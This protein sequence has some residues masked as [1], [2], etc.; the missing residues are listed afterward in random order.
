MENSTLGS[1]RNFRK[2]SLTPLV[3]SEERRR[4]HLPCLLLEVS[5]NTAA[6]PRSTCGLLWCCDNPA[7]TCTLNLSS[8]V[9]IT[10]DTS[11]P[12]HS[13]RQP[14]LYCLHRIQILVFYHSPVRSESISC[15]KL[16][17]SKRLPL[18]WLTVSQSSMHRFR[19]KRVLN[20]HRTLPHKQDADEDV[21]G[22]NET[23][24]IYV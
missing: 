9:I 21:T 10:H 19:I 5:P 7:R 1:L 23:H 24:F 4:R 18:E 20:F 6:A 14:G 12:H 13:L 11:T 15:W 2:N 16:L 22:F 3:D 17:E 8:Y